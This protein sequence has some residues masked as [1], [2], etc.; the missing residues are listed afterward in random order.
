MFYNIVFKHC[1][2]TLF[3]SINRLLW[4][5]I[6]NNVDIDMRKA[7]R[8]N[9]VHFKDNVVTTIDI[10]SIRIN[11]EVLPKYNSTIFYD[12]NTRILNKIFGNSLK[13]NTA[14]HYCIYYLLSYVEIY[15]DIIVFVGN[16]YKHNSKMFIREIKEIRSAYYE[17]DKF[18]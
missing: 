11:L 12:T 8:G 6:F 10:G 13:Y 3:L 2:I 7:I 16:D 18:K 1:F 9:I 17:K 4:Y 5:F 15:K 14:K